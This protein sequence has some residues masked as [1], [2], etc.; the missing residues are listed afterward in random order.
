[1]EIKE[2]FGRVAETEFKLERTLEKLKA[3]DRHKEYFENLLVAYHDRND[4]S[5]IA[6]LAA[7]KN[8]TSERMGE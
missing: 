7:L 2:L 3:K 8:F 6:N 5:F 1:M 4:V